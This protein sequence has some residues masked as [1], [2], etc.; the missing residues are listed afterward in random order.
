M[1]LEWNWNNWNE[2]TAPI[3]LILDNKINDINKSNEENNYT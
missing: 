3:S 2:I 1:E